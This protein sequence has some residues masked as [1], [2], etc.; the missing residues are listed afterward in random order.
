[1]FILE[2]TRGIESQGVSASATAVSYTFPAFRNAPFTGL[3]LADLQQPIPD[4]T[5]ETLPVMFGSVQ[6]LASNGGQATVADFGGTGSVGLVLVYYNSRTNRLQ[7]VGRYNVPAAA[8][9]TNT[10]TT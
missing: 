8:T 1:M 3:L 7:L 6:V 10:T 4:G 5:V 2:R 9:T